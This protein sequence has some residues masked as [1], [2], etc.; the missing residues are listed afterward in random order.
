M[1]L[2]QMMRR[3]EAGD[4]GDFAL[5]HQPLVDLFG[6]SDEESALAFWR[7]LPKT[8]L[9]DLSARTSLWRFGNSEGR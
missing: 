3:R 4:I 5:L 6:P 8:V 9:A 7:S 1:L 2:A